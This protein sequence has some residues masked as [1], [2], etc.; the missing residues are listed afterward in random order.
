VESREQDMKEELI[1]TIRAEEEDHKG[2]E[3]DEKMRG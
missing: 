1:G 2:G 3:G